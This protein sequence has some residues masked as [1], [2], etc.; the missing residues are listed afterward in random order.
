MAK[1]NLIGIIAKNP[2]N[3]SILKQSRCATGNN[4]TL[5]IVNWQ[6]AILATKTTGV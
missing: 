2:F 5:V 1:D 3:S 4:T 6:S